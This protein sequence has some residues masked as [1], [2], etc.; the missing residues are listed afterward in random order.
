MSRLRFGP[1]PED[2]FD[3]APPSSEEIE[4]FRENGFLVVER[5]TS[6][7]E[8]GWIR[9]IFDF[10]F[11]PS[12]AGKFGA[13]VDRTGTLA[14]GESPNLTQAFHPELRFPELLRTAHRRNAKRYAAALLGVDEDLLASWGHMI[15]KEPGGRAA[16]WHQDH[17]YWEPDFDYCAL[18]VWLPMHSVTAQMGAMQFVPGSHKRG[19]LPHRHDDDP[20][21]NVLTVAEPVDPARA[22]AC[23]L[24]MGGATFHH[25]Q[26][27]HY[28]APNSTDRPRLAYPVEFQVKPVRR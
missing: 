3:L 20:R 17:A 7:E 23:P 11:S 28:T 8:I 4:S 13:P 24:E 18:G 15:R 25:Y 16:L 2:D 21:V 26:T 10:I 9:Q 5:L 27:L 22:V 6:D 12:E 19:L 14:P 1:P